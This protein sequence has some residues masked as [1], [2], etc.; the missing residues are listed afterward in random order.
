MF[1]T[2]RELWRACR[3]WANGDDVHVWLFGRLRR[4]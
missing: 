3:A 1:A 2:L 4:L